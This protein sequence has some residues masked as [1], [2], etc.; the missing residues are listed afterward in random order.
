MRFRKNYLTELL[1]K[2][3]FSCDLKSSKSLKSFSKE[4]FFCSGLRNTRSLGRGDQHQHQDNQMVSLVL[5][6]NT[7]GTLQCT[8]LQIVGLVFICRLRSTSAVVT[9]NNNGLRPVNVFILTRVVII[10]LC[11][12]HM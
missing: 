7:N 12:A 5:P 11:P 10:P 1:Q 2:T 4:L 8:D 3:L 9:I 6:N